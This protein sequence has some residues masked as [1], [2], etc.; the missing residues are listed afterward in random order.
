M[1]ASYLVDG[2]VANYRFATID[3]V[4]KHLRVEGKLGEKYVPV[5][6]YDAVTPATR[7]RRV[8]EAVK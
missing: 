1:S 3:E 2:K 4:R 6:L 5:T 7:E 8:L